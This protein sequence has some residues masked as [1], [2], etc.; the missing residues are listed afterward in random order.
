LFL[1]LHNFT[2]WV[3][4]LMGLLASYRAIV[5]WLGKKNWAD[6]DKKVGLFFTI[7][8]DIQLLI[9]FLLYF[10][11]S[12]WALKA[13]LRIGMAEVME[14]SGL[15]YYAVEHVFY[16]ALGFVFAHLGSALPK[17]VDDSQIKFKLAAFW[18][19]LATIL[20]IVGIP[21]ARPLIPGI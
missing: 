6:T 19:G 7:S 20:I 2:R 3:V 21:W 1:A 16:M 15:R 14:N 9:G 11:F 17:K 13:I 12:E 10:V 8:V 18:I 4:L 5:G